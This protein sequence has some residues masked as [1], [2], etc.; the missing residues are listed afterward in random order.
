MDT[1]QTSHRAHAGSVKVGIL[2]AVGNG[3]YHF[4]RNGQLSRF[5]QHFLWY[6]GWFERAY[7]FSYRDDDPPGS[8]I[9]PVPK[10]PGISD[11][12]YAL[13]LPFRSAA[14]RSCDVFRVTSLLGAI[15]ALVGSY[16]FHKPFVVSYGV[17]YELVSRIHGRGRRE[18]RFR[19]LRRLV[20][21]KAACV[22]VPSPKQAQV[23]RWKHPT[24]NIKHH[25]NW[26]DTERFVPKSHGG[27][28][29]VLYVGRFTVEK[30]LI[31]LARAC[32]AVGAE[33]VTC[34]IGPV[35]PFPVTE[36]GIVDWLDLPAVY[37]SADVFGI[38]SLA[39]GHC[40]AWAEAMACGL[41]CLVS[42]RIDGGLGHV[43]P[44]EDQTAIERGLQKLLLDRELAGALS[45]KSRQFASVHYDETRLMQEE[46]T[47]MRSLCE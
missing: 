10:P 9:V 28:H 33:F 21:P 14:F 3:L 4:Q 43:V 35:R 29:R 40:K 31:R 46:V 39:E 41:P 11:F 19:W 1:A 12:L 17:D 45:R 20:L 15:P 2:P 37:Q 7:Y 6:Q 24:A 36:R 23:L 13:T 47:L 42:D 18:K 26:V 5:R 27:K 32:E 22:L 8:F 34:G 44:A 25:Y 16:L 38:I 30:N